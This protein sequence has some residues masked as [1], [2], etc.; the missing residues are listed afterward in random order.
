[1][2]SFYSPMVFEDMMDVFLDAVDAATHAPDDADL[3]AVFQDPIRSD[4][5]VC[6]RVCVCGGGGGVRVAVC[7]CA[8]EEAPHER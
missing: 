2:G 3:L 8:R 4:W 7:A 6:V 5:C 1:V